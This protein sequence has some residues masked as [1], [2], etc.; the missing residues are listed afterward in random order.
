MIQQDNPPLAPM[1]PASPPAPVLIG[2]PVFRKAAFGINHPL[3]I[4]R[5]E[6]VFDLIRDLGWFDPTAFVECLPATRAVISTF[7]DAAYLDALQRAEVT[8]IVEA[9]DRIQF[10]FGNMENPW[11]S[12]LFER[13]ATTVGGSILAAQIAM[14]NRTVFHPSGGTHHGLRDRANGFCYFND[15]VFAALTFL[16]AGLERIAYVDVDAHHG[17]GVEL[18]FARDPRVMTISVHEADRWPYSG[19]QSAPSHGIINLPVPAGCNDSEFAFC[20]DEIVMPALH[21]FEP[22]AIVITCGTDA[23]AGDPLSKMQLSNQCLW[24][25]VLALCATAPRRVIVGGGG[26]NPWTLAR[27]WTGLWGMLQGQQ[28]PDALSDDATSIL[29]NLTC[30]L[31]DDDEICGDWLTQLVDKRNPGHIRDAV[32]SLATGF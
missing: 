29:S 22:E 25:S 1:C 20:L 19:T 2:S 14:N 8:G 27:C 5:V 17:D 24:D 13:A 30:D 15:P 9:N 18:A 16:E 31:I 4:Q 7:H 26:Y 11:F 28:M 32:R 21:A 12:G 23:L 3:S 6:T 10:N